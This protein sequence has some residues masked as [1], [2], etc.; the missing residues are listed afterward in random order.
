MPTSHAGGVTLTWL[1]FPLATHSLFLSCGAG[2][3]I[4]RG[5]K[6]DRLGVRTLSSKPWQTHTFC[7]L[8]AQHRIV[9]FFMSGCTFWKSFC[10]VRPPPATCDVLFSPLDELRCPPCV[11][12]QQL[13]L[14]NDKF[15]NNF[16]DSLTCNRGIGTTATDRAPP[17]GLL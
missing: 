17:A 7:K 8:S 6:T 14:K 15:Q 10:D 13:Q 11:L 9:C 3:S 1:F 16:Y 4:W 2:Q 12:K 5:G